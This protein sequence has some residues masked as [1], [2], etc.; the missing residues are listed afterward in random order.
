MRDDCS[1]DDPDFLRDREGREPDSEDDFEDDY[2][3]MNES[4]SIIEGMP[5][6]EYQARPE[7]SSHDLMLFHRAPFAYRFAKDN[8][9]PEEDN[10]RL[11]SLLHLA[12]LEPDQLEAQV[13]ILP[14]DAKP[15]PLPAHHKMRAEGRELT[16]AAKVRFG[17]WDE[18]DEKTKGKQNVKAGDLAK[19][20]AMHKSLMATPSVRNGVSAEGLR[21][22]SAF[23]TY[24]GVAARMR[25]DIWPEDEIIDLKSCADCSREAFSREIWRQRYHSSASYYMEGS[26]LVGRPAKRFVWIA[27]ETKAPHLCSYHIAS[28]SLLEF[29]RI[30]NE[31]DLFMMDQCAAKGFWPGMRGFPEPIELPD[32][33]A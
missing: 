2:D 16:E 7:V 20:Q 13:A 28:T 33:A 29:G 21:E 26:K 10:M 15:K 4:P 5:M 3:D 19:V 11:G 9:E 18:W 24:N 22:A 27:I 23:F 32:Y 8:P 6:A 1:G 30:E 25:P 12:V 14:E 17:F 31:R